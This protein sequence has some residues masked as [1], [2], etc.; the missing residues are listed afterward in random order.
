MNRHGIGGRK[1]DADRGTYTTEEEYEFSEDD[2]MSE[3]GGIRLDGLHLTSW[4]S[5][6]LN[7]L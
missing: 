7:R 3:G 2:P 6:C 5:D 4:G 1:T